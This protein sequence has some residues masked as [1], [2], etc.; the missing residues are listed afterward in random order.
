MIAYFSNK[1]LQLNGDTEDKQKSSDIQS[2]TKRINF[3]QHRTNVNNCVRALR[4]ILAQ[5]QTDVEFDT[6]NDQHFTIHFKNIAFDL[7]EKRP[8]PREKTNNVFDS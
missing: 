4:S 6:G 8:R 5:K 2:L 7:K 1:I 3:C